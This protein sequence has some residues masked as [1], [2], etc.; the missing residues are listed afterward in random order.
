MHSVWQLWA[1]RGFGAAVFKEST[2][3]SPG[4]PGQQFGGAR[5]DC[6]LPKGQADAAHRAERF[7]RSAVEIRARESQEGH[8][9][10][11]NEPGTG[12]RADSQEWPAA[13]TWGL[14]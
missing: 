6:P 7:S 10:P 14:G 5:E 4:R 11:E 13:G 8:S 3:F 1:Q 12:A 9:D 2:S